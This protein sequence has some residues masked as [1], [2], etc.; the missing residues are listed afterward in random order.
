MSDT[1]LTVIVPGYNNK[2]EW[3]QRCLVSIINVTTASDEIIV[4]DDGS[5]L[6]N[7]NALAAY[8]AKLKSDAQI[9]VLRKTNGGLASARNAAL[10]EA[11]GKFVTFVDSDDELCNDILN[12]CVSKLEQSDCDICIYGVRVIWTEDGLCKEDVPENAALGCLDEEKVFDLYRKCLLNYS[13]NKV[14]RH[15]IV[16][17][18]RFDMDGMPCE[19]IIFN[20]ECIAKKATFCSVPEVGYL[21][22][23]RDGTLLSRYVSTY[24][25]G[26]DR[27]Y[28]LWIRLFGKAPFTKQ[29]ISK[30]K[31]MNLWRPGSPMSAF[32]RWRWLRNHSEVG[33]LLAYIKTFASMVLRHYVYIRPVRRWRI[34][35]MFPA[36]NNL[37]K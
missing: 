7:A 23:R 27:Q 26:V 36:V 8:V 10:A 21:Y 17:E 4:V 16:G 31:W 3:W 14:Y 18:T 28:E 20:F 30:C 2:I 35:H 25:Y 24:D 13:C 1:R 12:K 15:S 37:Q 11:K 33:G 6:D 29:Y 19:D 34:K 9:K 22:Y 32:E 5:K